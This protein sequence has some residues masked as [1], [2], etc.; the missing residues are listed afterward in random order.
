VGDGYFKPDAVLTRAEFAV[1]MNRVL[2][3]PA[4][5]I[6][7]GNMAVWVDNPY[8]TW[9]HWAL[10][11]ASNASPGALEVD[12]VALQLPYAVVN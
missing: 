3:R 8:G 9:Y 2:G 6:D 12:W 5:D 7:V 10:Q 11:I 1:L 4:A